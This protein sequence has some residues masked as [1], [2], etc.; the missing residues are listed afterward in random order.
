MD[1]INSKQKYFLFFI[2]GLFIGGM[3]GIITINL[4]IS[5]RIDN[6]IKEI[7]HLDKVIEEKDF[8]LKKLEKNI[9]DK[10]LLV[11][12]VEIELE[13]E[14]EKENDDIVKITLEKHIK[15]KFKCLVGK[16]VENVDGDILLEI[17]DRR[18][19]KIE[20][21]EYQLKL[22]RIMISQVVKLWIEIK[23]IK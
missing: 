11:K 23:V 5:Y 4:L 14:N 13:Y 1:S 3:V 21:K 12:N 9:Y 10:R 6:Y 2:L 20:D 17:I 19:M 16:E 15:D 22:K 8:R 18:I 7:K